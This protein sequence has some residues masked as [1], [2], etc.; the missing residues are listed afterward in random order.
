MTQ[1]EPA[2]DARE[3]A[4]HE[5]IA[6]Y[7]PPGSAITADTVKALRIGVERGYAAGTADREQAQAECKRLWLALNA[8]RPWMVLAEPPMSEEAFKSWNAVY[9]QMIEALTTTD[10]THDE[11][12]T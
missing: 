5:A 4:L 11:T 10:A 2:A 7:C 8:V 6:D 12:P 9:W 1:P 3:A